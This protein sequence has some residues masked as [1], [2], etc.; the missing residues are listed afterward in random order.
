MEYININILQKK[1]WPPKT[2][3]RD[4]LIQAF[5]TF[6][7]PDNV[8]WQCSG[9]GDILKVNQFHIAFLFLAEMTSP[10]F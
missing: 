1:E 10:F 3:E 9:P 5:P 4:H 6:E 8:S 7:N 2:I